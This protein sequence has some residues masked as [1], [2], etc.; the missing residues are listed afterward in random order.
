MAFTIITKL[1]EDVL[2]A[3]VQEGNISPS[4]LLALTDENTIDG[5]GELY[6][7]RQR[8]LTPEYAIKRLRDLADAI[9]KEL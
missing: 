3:H 9:E 1:N 5:A 4:V 6:L 7:I 8:N 2:A